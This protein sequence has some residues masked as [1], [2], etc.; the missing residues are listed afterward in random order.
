M[1]RS[2]Q[3]RTQDREELPPPTGYFER[4]SHFCPPV[5]DPR[6]PFLSERVVLFYL[7][8]WCQKRSDEKSLAPDLGQFRDQELA[9][10]ARAIA[11]NLRHD[12]ERVERLAA[13][14][15]EEW[16]LLERDLYRSVWRAPSA[17]RDDCMAEARFKI[18]GAIGIGTKPTCAACRLDGRRPRRPE[19]LNCQ[20]KPG[21][22]GAGSEYLFQ[23]PFSGW[24]GA[25][26]ANVTRDWWRRFFAEQRRRERPLHPDPPQID[27]AEARRLLTKTLPPLAEAIR[28]LSGK[29]QR[30]AIVASFSCTSVDPLAGECLRELAPDLFEG[31]G[32]NMFRNDEELANHLGSDPHRV[33]ANRSAARRELCRKH[34]ELRGPLDF[35]MPHQSTVREDGARDE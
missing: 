23:S 4:L 22:R 12:G 31:Y 13:E 33:Q 3:S 21:V 6:L 27:P 8:R 5:Y 35:F 34:P 2:A 26:A 14:D 28:S 9:E 30:E 24:T 18:V 7:A 10:T 32:P 11:T 19:C 17:A 1:A 15:E 25:I 16:R 29:K 20:S